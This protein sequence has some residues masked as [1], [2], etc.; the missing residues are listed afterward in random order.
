MLYS[1][2][3]K[4]IFFFASRR[5]HT[6]YWRDW[7]SDVCSSDLEIDAGNGGQ[8]LVY[9][10]FQDGESAVIPLRTLSVLV[11][12]GTEIGRASCRERAQIMVGAVS[13]KKRS[14]GMIVCRS[15]HRAI[16]LRSRV[17]SI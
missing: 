11:N 12:P 2:T 4:Y 10:S 8:L 13:L 6:R 17:L 5:R 9:E 7:S 3:N 1:K 15:S 16:A 14:L